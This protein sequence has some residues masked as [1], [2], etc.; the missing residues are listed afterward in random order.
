MSRLEWEVR[1]AEPQYAARDA[2]VVIVLVILGG[3][4]LAGTVLLPR[5][6]PPLLFDGSHA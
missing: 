1:Q 4:G 3:G 6:T 5:L 2:V